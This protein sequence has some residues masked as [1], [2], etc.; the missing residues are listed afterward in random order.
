MRSEPFDVIRWRDGRI[1]FFCFDAGRISSRSTG[2]P[3]DTR[4]SLLMRE[5]IQS[6]GCKGGGAANC[7]HKD[8]L[9]G[10]KNIGLSFGGE[11]RG[12]TVSTSGGYN[13]S[14]YGSE[15]IKISSE[16]SPSRSN[17]GF[18]AHKSQH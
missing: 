16:S 14:R 3:R 4:K 5:R 7:D 9:L 10:L 8:A 13:A 11:G 12:G 18:K 6:G 2:T 1:S 17:I 15:A